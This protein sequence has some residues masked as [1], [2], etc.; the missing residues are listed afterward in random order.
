MKQKKGKGDD[1][2]APW[3]AS[4]P[5]SGARAWTGAGS[6]R[7]PGPGPR[8][9]TCLSHFFLGVM[10]RWGRVFCRRGRLGARSRSS[11][12]LSARPL[13]VSVVLVAP[14]SSCVHSAA[15]SF[16]A[17]ATG[18][19]APA[20]SVVVVVSRG[21]A[22][23][24]SLLRL[25]LIWCFSVTLGKLDFDLSAANPL[26]VQAVQGV[27]SISHILKHENN[28]DLLPLPMLD[29]ELDLDLYTL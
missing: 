2:A 27:F 8:G 20:V 23:G 12:G 1:L 17:A 28:S 29:F 4:G 5:R 19:P 14:A 18:A 6:W 16:I 10:G 25:H 7:R 3:L 11:S 9:G 21:S 26:P 15:G 22:R 13:P 24:A